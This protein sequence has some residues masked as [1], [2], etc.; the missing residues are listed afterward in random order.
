MRGLRTHRMRPDTF[1]PPHALIPFVAQRLPH[2]V[3]CLL[4]ARGARSL[5]QGATV[6]SFSLYLHALGFSGTA[7]GMI[8]MAG[9]AFGALLTLII[10]PLSDRSSR[11][12]LLIGYEL[13]AAAAALAVIITP[14][15]AVLI[16]A[17]TLA[18][19][20]RGANGA[21]GPFSPVEQAWIAREVDGE[22]RRRALAHNATLGFLGMGVGALLVA[23][24]PLL[25]HGYHQ[26]A[27]F[28][29]LFT[30][31]LLSAL[32]A[33]GLIAWTREIASPRPTTVRDPDLEAR[34]KRDENRLIRKLALTN[35]VN[36]LAIGVIAPLIAYWFLRRYGAGPAAIGPALAASFALAM[37]GSVLAHWLSH[38]IGTVRAVTAMRIVGLAMLIGIPFSEDFAMAA[39]LYA[40]RGVFN[41]GTAGV[42]QAVAA[43]LT[44]AER[45]GMA[46]TVQNL[47]MQIPRAVGPVIGGWLIHRGEFRTP[48]LIAAALQGLYIV[49]YQRFFGSMEP[50]AG[51]TVSTQTDA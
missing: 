41:R 47:S 51:G 10:G 22:A 9:L 11:R 27:S 18:G 39:S 21:A 25:G 31:P 37:L 24:P 23:V 19:F 20:G 40:I 3:R 16:A 28:R 13:A 12:R 34:L 36:G 50:A 8:L 33:L 2:N 1:A 4:A 29:I 44:R 48:F 46:A 6:A 26:L 43:G 14:N 49:L 30:L 38:R 42:R 17:S 32:A 35:A 15:E 5:G 45:R 7:I